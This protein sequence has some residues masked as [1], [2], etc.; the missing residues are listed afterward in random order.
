M[1]VAN[2][3]SERGI[4]MDK[5]KAAILVVALLVIWWAYRDDEKSATQIVVPGSNAGTYTNTP[6]YLYTLATSGYSQTKKET[7]C[8]VCDGT[9]KRSCPACDGQGGLQKTHYP[10]DFGQGSTPYKTITR[11]DLCGGTGEADCR[12]CQG[13]GWI[14]N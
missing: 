3:L 2:N 4:N 12:Y 8:S 6:S 14:T 9:G 1:S 13:N 11:C 7:K 5:K 10:I